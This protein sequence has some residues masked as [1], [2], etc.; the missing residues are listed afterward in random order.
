MV[1][2]TDAKR[3]AEL[4][5]ATLQAVLDLV[6]RR[7]R[8]TVMVVDKDQARVDALALVR[9][10]ISNMLAFAAKCSLAM[11]VRSDGTDDAA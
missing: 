5:Q 1:N 8:L 10:D 3:R 6:D 2:P 4:I 7:I 11:E 9:S